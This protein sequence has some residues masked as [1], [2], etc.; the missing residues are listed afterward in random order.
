MDGGVPARGQAGERSRRDAPDART[1]HQLTAPARS[2]RRRPFR[3]G[4]TLIAGG[5]GRL[6]QALGSC[7]AARKAEDPGAVG[8]QSVSLSHDGRNGHCG[9]QGM[10]RASLGDRQRPTPRPVF[11][12]GHWRYWGQYSPWPDDRLLAACG[13][14]GIDSA[15]GTSP[16]AAF[17]KI[18]G[19]KKRGPRHRVWCVAFSP[20]G[21]AGW[22]S[23]TE[24]GEGPGSAISRRARE[25]FLNPDPQC[26]SIQSSGILVRLPGETLTVF[27]RGQGGDGIAV[28]RIGS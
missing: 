23:A 9:R 15:C 28:R 14:D 26:N 2:R 13:G 3:D 4:R 12:G 7:H 16:P 18:W 20:A 19:E 8:I 21:H 25:W 6:G 27:A 1:G 11:S 17:R 10:I 24:L 22:L 5:W